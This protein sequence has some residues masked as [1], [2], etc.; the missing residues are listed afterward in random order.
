MPARNTNIHSTESGQKN[1]LIYIYTVASK[2]TAPPLYFFQ[3][4]FLCPC[5]D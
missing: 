2:I 4:K 3:M 1:L 5:S